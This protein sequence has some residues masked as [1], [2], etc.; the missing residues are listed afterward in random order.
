MSDYKY[1]I[2]HAFGAC[3]HVANARDPHRERDVKLFHIPGDFTVV[4]ISDGTDN[5]ISP[6]T[7][8]P[9]SVGIARIFDDIRAGKSVEV[10]TLSRRRNR[11]EP[12]MQLD[13]SP[14]PRTRVRVEVPQPTRTR[15][16]V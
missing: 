6:I 11:I 15:N 8:D 4:G 16:R 12:Q 7:V 10:T 1:H 5:W 2:S 13:L 9:F 14:A 3:R